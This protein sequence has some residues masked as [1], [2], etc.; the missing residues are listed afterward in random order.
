MVSASDD[1]TCLIWSGDA[2]YP[3]Q[4]IQHDFPVLAAAWSKDGQCV[5]SA[6][7]ENLIHV[8]DIRN[9]SSPVYSLVGHGDTITGL[10]VSNDGNSL[11]STA[12]DNSVKVW[13][14]KPFAINPTRLTVS[15]DGIPFHSAR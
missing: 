4:K 3:T 9:T 15:F 12:M 10:A 14:L 6:G 5:Y 8:H 11:V 1:S 2:K 7:I 13:D